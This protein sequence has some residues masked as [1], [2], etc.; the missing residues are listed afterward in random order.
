H[1]HAAHQ[2]ADL[3]PRGSDGT[4]AELFAHYE[5]VVT[6]W[7]CAAQGASWLRLHRGGRS[8][9]AVKVAA[10]AARAAHE[11]ADRDLPAPPVP[12]SEQPA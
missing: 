6:D 2:L 4:P 10:A 3:Q 11:A 7:L 8:W 5:A 9:D 1:S 12:R